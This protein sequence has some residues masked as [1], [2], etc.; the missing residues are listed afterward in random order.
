MFDR[1][2]MPCSKNELT[3]KSNKKGG[4]GGCGWRE[5]RQKW[6]QKRNALF[7]FG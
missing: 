1:I 7:Y 4:G 5:C 6:I 3:D 2:F